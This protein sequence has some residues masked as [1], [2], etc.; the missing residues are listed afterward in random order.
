MSGNNF[1][2]V[3]SLV[4]SS[5]GVDK[6]EMFNQAH[7]ILDSLEAPISRLYDL[8]AFVDSLQHNPETAHLGPGPD[9]SIT[10]NLT[11]AHYVHELVDEPLFTGQA[12]KQPLLFDKLVHKITQSINTDMQQLEEF[13]T[14]AL[15]Q[16]P[17]QIP[18]AQGRASGQMYLE[19]ASLLGSSQLPSLKS[20][21]SKKSQTEIKRQAQDLVKSLGR[22]L[23]RVKA[24][25]LEQ[26]ARGQ[27]NF[28][29]W[30]FHD[31]YEVSE[32]LALLRGYVK[33]SQRNNRT[34]SKFMASK[35]DRVAANLDCHMRALMVAH[36]DVPTTG[37]PTERRSLNEI[38]RRCDKDHDA[39]EYRF[40]DQHSLVNELQDQADPRIVEETVGCVDAQAISTRVE[41]LHS[42]L[43]GA[44]SM[45]EPYAKTLGES[46]FRNALGIL[47]GLVKADIKSLERLNSNL[48]I[49][50]PDPA[51]AQAEAC[52]LKHARLF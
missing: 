35:L 20:S 44:R 30:G 17:D 49:L 38:L 8:K 19:L 26:V 9:V 39:V 50:S 37:T 18:S 15:G 33:K 11:M 32:D 48:R 28:Y 40:D 45:N 1:I 41:G 3:P 22:Q 43:R 52:R 27:G 4:D 21:F 7:A 29:T 16:L 31:L 13:A 10:V 36:S 34:I 42:L 47:H 25:A 2:T 12:F 5:Q 24:V 14:R 51:E 6:E 46:F 23:D